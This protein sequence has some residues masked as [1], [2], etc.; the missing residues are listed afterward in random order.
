MRTLLCATPVES[1]KAYCIYH[2]FHICSTLHNLL[3]DYHLVE[4]LSKVQQDFKNK[5]K[6]AFR[7]ISNEIAGHAALKLPNGALFARLVH[8]QIENCEFIRFLCL[9]INNCLWC[10]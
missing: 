2:L 1:H 5:L 9:L 10:L 8:E 6:K 4:I 3:T 7:L